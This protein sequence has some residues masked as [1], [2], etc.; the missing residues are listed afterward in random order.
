MDNQTWHDLLP[1][2]IE[3]RLSPAETRELEHRLARD[4]VLHAAYVEWQTIAGVVQEEASKWAAQLP[5]LSERVKSQL[6]VS[7]S[8]QPNLAVPVEPTRVT[9][10]PVAPPIQTPPVNN[11]YEPTQF[12][13]IGYRE[14]AA[15]TSAT[16][17]FPLSAVAAA[18]LML[19]VGIFLVYFAGGFGSDEDP[20]TVGLSNE[21]VLSTP[22]LTAFPTIDATAFPTN[23]DVPSNLPPTIAPDIPTRTPRPAPTEGPSDFDDNS[24]NGTGLNPSGGG[25]GAQPVATDT[26]MVGPVDPNAPCQATTLNDQAVTVYGSPF[27][28][29]IQRPI[30]V[31]ELWNIVAVSDTGWFEV[32]SPFAPYERGW[33]YGFDVMLSGNCADVPMPTATQAVVPTIDLLVTSITP[34]A[35]IE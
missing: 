21:N 29:A 17:R 14:P 20:T 27:G 16:R 5:P 2:Y 23:T 22:T 8:T 19:F 24:I 30:Y 7:Q 28:V 3:G 9:R 33:V 6:G 32:V 12:G 1:L 25:T 11:G 18:I 4:P 31:G 15:K 13:T 26:P 35:S 34:E 10:L